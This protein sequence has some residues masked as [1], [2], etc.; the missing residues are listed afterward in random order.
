ML[1]LTSSEYVALLLLESCSNRS[2]TVM[3]LQHHISLSSGN[4]AEQ[5]ITLCGVARH[6]VDCCRNHY[7]S[8]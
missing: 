8:F 4:F 3:F 5:E 6:C 7:I 2:F 1:R